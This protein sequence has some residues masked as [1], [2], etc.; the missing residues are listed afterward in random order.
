MERA[1]VS[2]LKSQ[3]ANAV[4]NAIVGSEIS[5]SHIVNDTIGML[6]VALERAIKPP[7]EQ[8]PGDVRGLAFDLKAVL[9]RLN[10]KF[11]FCV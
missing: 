2:L 10:K 6:L 4:V 8:I 3:N 11:R 1:E 5:Y 9:G 7:D